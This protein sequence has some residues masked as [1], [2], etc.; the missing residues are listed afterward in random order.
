M[1]RRILLFAVLLLAPL[2]AFGQYKADRQSSIFKPSDLV[3]RP[4][5]IFEGLID[6]SRFQMTQSYSISFLTF[7]SQAFN[8]GLY[9]NTLSYRISDPLLARVQIGYMHQP[10]GGRS[11]SGSSNGSLFV[12]SASL[13]Y[14]PSDRTRIFFDYESMPAPVLSPYAR[15]WTR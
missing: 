5:G 9:L 12:R 1:R 10:F 15:N 14:N 11:L 2:S 13:E 8:Q 7:G 4:A 6:P 3:Q